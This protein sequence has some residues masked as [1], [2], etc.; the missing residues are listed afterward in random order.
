MISI[1]ENKSDTVNESKLAAKKILA[2]NY[3][4]I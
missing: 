1:N 4:S 2:T 3:S